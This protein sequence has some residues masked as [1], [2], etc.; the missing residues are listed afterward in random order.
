[1]ELIGLVNYALFMGIFIGIYAL[2]AL[3]LNVQWGFAGLFN[4]GIAGFFAVGAYTSAILTSAAADGRI[5]GF[6]L[7][8]IFGWVAAMIAAGAI[9]WPIGKICL[10]FRSDY[11]AIATI[12]VA[13]IIRLVIKSEETLTNSARGI[14][15]LPRPFG[16]LPYVESQAAYLAI[17]ILVLA[18]IYFL[19]QRQFNSPWGR[20][21]RAIRD[22]ELAARAMGKDIEYRRLEAFIFGAAIMG[23]AGAMFAHFNRSIT[24]E[25]IDPM[26]ATFLVWIM[27]ILGGS[28]NNKGAILGAAVVWIIWSVSEIATDQLPHEY[29][30]KAK[31]I[32]LF[33]IGLLLQLVL[34]F[35][36]EGLLPE[37]LR[38]EQHQ[39]ETGQQSS[40]KS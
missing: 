38:G 39:A 37:P 1:M 21:M 3:G 26:V 12:G 19:V 30:V 36:S 6:D 28:G 7:P 32:R 29:A 40:A 24:P 22:N 2:L 5:G 35:R 23:L 4:A 10:R 20:M 8:F 27:L 31:Y 11:L 33:L 34:R 16:D 9:A 18:L 17:V 13:E 14:T 25:A 15:G